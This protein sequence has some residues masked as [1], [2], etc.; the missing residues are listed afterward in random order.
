MRTAIRIEHPSSSQALRYAECNEIS[1][2]KPSDLLRQELVRECDRDV[3][4][5][6]AETERNRGGSEIPA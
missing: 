5:G 3:D 1:V 2:D 6:T 4:I